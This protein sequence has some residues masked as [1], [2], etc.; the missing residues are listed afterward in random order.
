MMPNHEKNGYNYENP[1]LSLL[2]D[3]LC[4]K[5]NGKKMLF[6]INQSINIMYPIAENM[7]II[8]NHKKNGYNFG[9]SCSS[10]L[11]YEL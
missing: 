3:E 2:V 5:E 11:A 4:P 8:P 1:C 6:L 10:P 9:N 7:F